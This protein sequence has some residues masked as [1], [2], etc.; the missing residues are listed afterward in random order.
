M[1]LLWPSVCPPHPGVPTP[2]LVA[3][4]RRPH[5]DDGPHGGNHIV[6]R[7]VLSL[8][9]ST[10]GQGAHTGPGST[11]GAQGD[12]KGRGCPRSGSKPIPPPLPCP[13]PRGPDATHRFLL[14]LRYVPRRRG[15]Q[16]ETNKACVLLWEGASGPKLGWGVTRKP[17]GGTAP[18][19]KGDRAGGAHSVL[20]LPY[21]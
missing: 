5:Q 12:A 6:G 17:R 8:W 18:M 1:E 14:L 7:H 2:H 11:A 16:G 4:Q 20:M 19:A 9:G 10:G 3:L 13:K 15:G 21:S